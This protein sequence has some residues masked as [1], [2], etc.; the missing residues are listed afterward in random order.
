MR[1]MHN[2]A[3]SNKFDVLFE[4]LQLTVWDSIEMEDCDGRENI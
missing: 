2:M 4:E 3:R 1:I